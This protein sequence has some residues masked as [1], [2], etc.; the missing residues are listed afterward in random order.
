MKKTISLEQQQQISESTGTEQGDVIVDITS[1]TAEVESVTLNINDPESI[2]TKIDETI[3]K[4]HN[5]L[6][7]SWD[8]NLDRDISGYEIYKD[9]KLLIRITDPNII[10][11]TDTDL[12][13]RQEY[14]Y[15]IY[16]I[17]DLNNRSDPVSV[18]A[19]SPDYKPPDVPKNLKA[20]SLES[21]IQLNWDIINNTDDDFQKYVI[22][23]DNVKVD[24]V[25]ELETTTY[26]VKKLTNYKNYTLS[27]TAVDN[28]GN[29]SEKSNS[30][31]TNPIDLT[32][33]DDININ[34]IR[35][36]EGNKSLTFRWPYNDD[37]NKYNVFENKGLT[38]AD[39][40]LNL[41][42]IWNNI[43]VGDDSFENTLKGLKNWNKYRFV[44]KA[45]DS[46]GNISRGIIPKTQDSIYTNSTSINI[47]PDLISNDG[48][49][50][51][52]PANYNFSFDF[53]FPKINT[54]KHNILFLTKNKN[55]DEKILLYSNWNTQEAW[56]RFGKLVI[57]KTNEEL[58]EEDSKYGI[59]G[60]K[61]RYDEDR[62]E[63]GKDSD[64]LVILPY[65][66]AYNL[67]TSTTNYNEILTNPKYFIDNGADWNKLSYD[68][69]FGQIQVWGKYIFNNNTTGLY[70]R[71]TDEEF[72]WVNLSNNVK[73]FSVSKDTYDLSQNEF[74]IF[75][76]NNAIQL[77]LLILK[78]KKIY[79]LY[80]NL[81]MNMNLRKYL[82]LHLIYL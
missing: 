42:A 32:P 23:L 63:D 9:N 24:E 50:I 6:F 7:L 11:Y 58:S 52:M 72:N 57:E 77:M 37:V 55:F 67:L 27:I 31:T 26:T 13:Q 4:I 10:K 8:K 56:E 70:Y 69:T 74:C 14:T 5:T 48:D 62:K 18:K 79:L 44:I 22:Y 53:L 3:T 59:T 46:R 54:E 28:L 51:T 65:S 40:S 21:S 15:T 68:V 19:V 73:E 33:P 78:V 30:V 35:I 17:D 2:E 16:N 38:V 82:F 61:R 39:N 49:L 45:I 43:N 80:Q 1:S 36:I 20:T 12:I 47:T 76:I 25:V 60:I 29:E 64:T 41:L 34:D 71:K 81:I 66:P 75:T